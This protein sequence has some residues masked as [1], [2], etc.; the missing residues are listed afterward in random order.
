MK[1]PAALFFIS[2]WLTSTADMDADC[3]GW[4]LNLILH[5]YD[6]ETLPNDLEKLAVLASVKFSEFERFKQVFEQVLVHKFEQL[7]NSRLSNLRTSKILQ[8]RENFKEKR[9]ASGK[10]SYFLKYC[11]ENHKSKIDEGLIV[12]IKENLNTDK[13]DTK[14][15][16]MLEQVFEHLFELYRNGSGNGSKI[17]IDFDKLKDYWN[18][19]CGK[20]PKIKEFTEARKKLVR[21]ILKTHTKQDLMKAILTVKNSNFLQGEN[22]NQWIATIDFFLNKKNFIKIIEGNYNNKENAKTKLQQQGVEYKDL[23][24]YGQE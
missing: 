2:D 8:S 9:S 15:K 5:N 10:L 13:L 19:N 6:K 12:F 14:N 17:E 1:D 7:P 21:S 18:F 20:C 23:T 16:Q 24:Y 11:R 4:Y 3:R 22:E